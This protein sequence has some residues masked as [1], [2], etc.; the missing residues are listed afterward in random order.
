M[1]QAAVMIG[2]AIG[3]ALG[4]PFE[5]CNHEQI[6]KSD[7]HG[8]YRAGAACGVSLQAGQ[9]TDDTKM[10]ICIA[11][12][13]VD[14]NDYDVNDVAGRYVKWYNSGDLRGIGIQ[15]S[16]AL[17][18]MITGV[19]LPK[20]GEILKKSKP[21][22]RRDGLDT[23]VCGNGTAMRIAPLGVF[24]RENQVKIFKHSIQDAVITHNHQ[25]AKDASL[26]VAYITGLLVN[27]INPPEAIEEAAAL[28]S[29]NN[30]VKQRFAFHEM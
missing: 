11:Q 13:L 3:D 9:W 18:N 8:E 23:N 22:F 15:T 7:W 21:S 1:K 16:R 14:N 2:L 4:Q 12:S 17:Q 5:F 20:C 25:D 27:G 26:I 19:P 10:A 28:L 29:G 6:T 30:N 24:F